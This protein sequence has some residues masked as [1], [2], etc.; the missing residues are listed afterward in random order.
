MLINGRPLGILLL[1]LW[2]AAH[3]IPLSLLAL[4]ASGAKAFLAWVLVIGALLVAIGLLIGWRIARY[5]AVLGVGVHVFLFAVAGWAFLFVALAW[6][7][8]ASEAPVVGF[9]LAYLLFT[10]WAFMYLFHPDVA[11]S[12]DQ[13][14]S[15]AAA[16]QEAP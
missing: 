10:F 13:P 14:R 16:L 12:F 3:T 7:L 9:I 4:D 6:G 8:H 11:H 1:G 5:L 2:C 15:F